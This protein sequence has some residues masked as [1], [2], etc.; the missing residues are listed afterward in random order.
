LSN[1]LLEKLE[2]DMNKCSS[3]KNIIIIK[4]FAMHFSLQ[5]RSRDGSINEKILSVFSEKQADE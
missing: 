1:I 2:I 5:W 4:C 3:A